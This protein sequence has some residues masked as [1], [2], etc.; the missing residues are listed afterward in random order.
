MILSCPILEPL[1]VLLKIIVSVSLK[2]LFF[3]TTNEVN[4]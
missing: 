4:L 1:F 2:L 3:L